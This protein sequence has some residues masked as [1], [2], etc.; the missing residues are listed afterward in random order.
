MKRAKSLESAKVPVARGK[1]GSLPTKEV[2][3]ILPFSGRK[4]E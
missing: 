4:A 3:N 1:R 2:N